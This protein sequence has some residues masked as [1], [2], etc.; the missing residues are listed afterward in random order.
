MWVDEC[1]VWCGWVHTCTFVYYILYISMTTRRFHLIGLLVL[2][3][4][5]IGDVALEFSKCMIYFKDRNGRTYYWPEL[6]ANM[7]FGFFTI[8]Q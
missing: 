7:G 8:Q 6:I 3:V 2:F 5:D 1:V 4:Q